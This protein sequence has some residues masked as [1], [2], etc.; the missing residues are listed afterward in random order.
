MPS[1][2]RSGRFLAGLFLSLSVLTGA[3]GGLPA[4]SADAYKTGHGD[5]SGMYRIDPDH[6]SVVFAVGHAGVGTVIGRFDTIRGHYRLDPGKVDVKIDILSKSVDTNHA[7]RDKDLRG[8]D[9]LDSK[10]FPHIRFVATTFKKT[11]K[12]SGILTGKLTI[13]G[14][15][16]MV[17][18]H[19][20][21]VGAAEVSALPK[22]WGG[23]LTGY[24]A[25]GVIHRK[26]FG[27]TTY[28]AM[29]G[30]TV[31]LYIDVEGVRVEK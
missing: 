22:P 10:T 24:D 14:K 9:F 2:L 20:R 29:I 21:E 7:K 18:L 4:A 17:R 30:D 6:S 28:P 19:V 27:I 8:P 3:F 26:D 13:R 1:S 12:V 31:H 15:T 16:R 11:G 25:E 23:Y 5:P